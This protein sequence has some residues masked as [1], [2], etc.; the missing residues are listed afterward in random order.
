[1]IVSVVVTTTAQSFA[2]GGPEADNFIS[3][4]EAVFTSYPMMDEVISSASLP[5]ELR[6]ILQRFGA[7]LPE[8]KVPEKVRGFRLDLNG[9]KSS[10]YFLET[11]MGGSG[12]PHYLVGSMWNGDWDIIHNF[13][14]G[15]HLLP[16]KAGWHPIVGISPRWRRHLQ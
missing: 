13:Q 6:S 11:S 7:W 4:P 9:D 12:G 14:G 8:Y 5:S 15:F 16:M 1:M 10:E 2:N 3:V